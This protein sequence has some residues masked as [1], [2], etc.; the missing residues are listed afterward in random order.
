MSRSGAANR[1]RDK[2][3]YSDQLYCGNGG[4][5]VMQHQMTS[6]A[7]PLL[8]ESFVSNGR[9]E[10]NLRRFARAQRDGGR[11]SRSCTFQRAQ[12]F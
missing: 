8:L 7:L 9:S 5:H 11:K 10:E 1:C 6:R 3:S 4:A 12:N 2:S